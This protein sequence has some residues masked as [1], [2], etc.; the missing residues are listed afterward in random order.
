MKNVYIFSRRYFQESSRIL[1]FYEGSRIF[2]KIY[3]KKNVTPFRK[4]QKKIDT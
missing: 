2:T 1:K 4:K 3:F